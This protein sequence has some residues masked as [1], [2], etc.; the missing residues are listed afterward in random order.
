MCQSWNVVP[1]AY[2]HIPIM[3]LSVTLTA[4]YGNKYDL[5]IG[6]SPMLSDHIFNNKIPNEKVDFD[7]YLY[8]LLKDRLVDY[9]E[10]EVIESPYAKVDF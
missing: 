9:P 2:M 4:S 8:H 6:M 5:E 7:N 10:L 1:V 3:G